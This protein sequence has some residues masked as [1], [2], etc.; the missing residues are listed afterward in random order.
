MPLN[1]P[2]FS[3]LEKTSLC[4]LKIEDWGNWSDG[5]STLKFPAVRVVVHIDSCFRRR[6][7]LPITLQPHGCD[8]EPRQMQVP[9]TFIPCL[10]FTS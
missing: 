7:V 1:S 5:N 6:A 3:Y 8:T 2:V 4:A 9:R 10:H